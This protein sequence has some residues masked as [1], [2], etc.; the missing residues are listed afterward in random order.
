MHLR[1]YDQYESVEHTAANWDDLQM[2]SN[3]H[4]RCFWADWS[5][6]KVWFT[7]FHPRSSLQIWSFRYSGFCRAIFSPE[8]SPIFRFF[9]GS[10]ANCRLFLNLKASCAISKSHA[11]QADG[12]FFARWRRRIIKLLLFKVHHVYA[13]HSIR[14]V[15]IVCQ[16]GYVLRIMHVRYNKLP[17]SYQQCPGKCETT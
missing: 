1:R 7:S 16:N 13:L 8:W 12:T 6:V 9:D 5:M 4:N 15:K 14:R 10:F 3:G 11:A 17:E 2:A